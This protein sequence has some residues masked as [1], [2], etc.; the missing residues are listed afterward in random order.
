MWIA[1]YVPDAIAEHVIDELGDQVLVTED[2]SAAT[3]QLD[4]GGESP[5][6]EWIYALAAPFPTIAD[7]IATQDLRAA[8]E[9]ESPA[10]FDGLP[11]MM[12]AATLGVLSAYWG[13]P[14]DGA[15]RTLPAGEL[16]SAAWD[17]QPSWAVIPFEQLTPQW[18]VLQIDGQSPLHKDFDPADLQHLPLGG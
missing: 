8:W 14:V 1:D 15:V 17:Q 7:G 11:L 18:K 4:V 6:A 16:L 12:D 3:W 5:F 10:A 9:G 13:Q 2:E